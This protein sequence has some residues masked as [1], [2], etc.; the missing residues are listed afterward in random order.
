MHQC[1]DIFHSD[2]INYA[3]QLK[4]PEWNKKRNEILLRDNYR[5][6]MCGRGKSKRTKINDKFYNF[7]ID[8]TFSHTATEDIIHTRLSTTDLKSLIHAENISIIKFTE[9]CAGLSSNG[10]LGVMDSN[11]IDTLKLNDKSKFECNLVRHK[12][13]LLYFLVNLVDADLSKIETPTIY[14]AEAPLLLNVHHKHYIVQ[15][16]AWEYEDDD[17]VTLCNECHTKIHQAIGA[18]VYSN[19]NGFMKEVSLTPCSR[20]NG[21]GYFPEYEHVENGI[22]FRC[23]GARFEELIQSDSH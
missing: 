4:S 10:I 1:F 2:F 21:T 11:A 15:H 20:C 7:G 8:Y 19:E 9:F 3:E 22:C 14:L 13:G 6:K 17:L 12:S 16:K 5:C 23:R 18:P